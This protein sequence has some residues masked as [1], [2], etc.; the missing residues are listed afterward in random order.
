MA[1]SSGGDE[2]DILIYFTGFWLFV[3]NKQFRNTWILDFKR[4]NL[5][6]KMF[7]LLEAAAAIVIG[8]VL[9]FGILVAL[10][11]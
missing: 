8:V 7:D 5:L 4:Q 9:P 6:S 1:S 10:I 3:F 11:P 2:F